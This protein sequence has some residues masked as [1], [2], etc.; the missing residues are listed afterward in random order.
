MSDDY[1]AMVQAGALALAKRENGYS[2]QG[3]ETSHAQTARTVIDAA[4]FIRSLDTEILADWMM[5]NGYATGHG[6]DVAALVGELDWQH[7]ERMGWKPIKTA[8]KNGTVIDVWLGN[9]SPEDVEF[10]CSPGTRRSANWHWFQGRFRPFSGL[11]VLV[12]TVDPTHWRPLPPPAQE[13]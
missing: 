10:Y 6:D 4:N 7:R 2:Y 8:P 5:A 9:A 13:G 11:N 1:E 3:Y 12:T